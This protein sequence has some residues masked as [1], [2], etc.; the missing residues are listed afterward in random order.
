MKEI[1]TQKQT[2]INA[3][4]MPFPS[5]FPRLE[6]KRTTATTTKVKL[7]LLATTAAA[8]LVHERMTTATKRT[9]LEGITSL[10]LIIG[11]ITS[12]KAGAQLG[13]TQD[14]V[15]LVDGSHLLLGVFLADTLLVGLVGVE[16]LG[17]LAVRRLDLSLVCV[18]GDAE[19][20]V[21]VLLLAALERYLGFLEDGV[22]LVA[23][24]GAGFGGAV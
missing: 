17:C 8:L 18:G 22:D 2:P 9:A 4:Q 5:L 16:L 15:R 19:D 23:L 21:V 24:V 7:K 13:V 11:I 6:P 20:L 14:F 10:L 12:V 1:I 3:G